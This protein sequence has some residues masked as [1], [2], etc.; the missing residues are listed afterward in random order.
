[1]RL[2]TPGLRGRILLSMTVITAVF[3]GVALLLT[4][5]LTQRWIAASLVDSLTSADRF[6][7]EFFN[8]NATNLLKRTE[9]VA[10]LPT[11]TAVVGA[12]DHAAALEQARYYRDRMGVDEIIIG[13]KQ[14]RLLARTDRPLD[15]G[16]PL[17]E[18][19]FTRALA[20]EAG[21]ELATMGSQAYQA[22]TVRLAAGA[23]TVGTFDAAQRLTDAMAE[24]LR[25]AT[26]WDVSFLVENRVVASSLDPSLRDLLPM[27]LEGRRPGDS[28]AEMPAHGVRPGTTS[29]VVRL[30]GERFIVHSPDLPAATNT[31]TLVCVVQRSLDAALAPYRRLQLVLG[32]AALLATALAG[33][34]GVVVARSVAD[35]VG[36]VAEAARVV[37]AGGWPPPIP[38][39]GGDEM[40]R[41][42]ATFNAMVAS[43]KEN[44]AR[45]AR[46]QGQERLAAVGQLAAG[47]AHDFNN[48]LMGIMS[49]AEVL[50][51]RS[52]LPEVVHRHLA[53]ILQQGE[54]AAKMIRQI[55]DF[56][57]KAPSERRRL[58]LGPAVKETMKLMERTLP[59]D[60]TTRLE[61]EAGEH[62][63]V[64]DLSQFQQVLTNLVVNAR[65]AMGGGGVLHVR[66]GGLALEEVVRT[67]FAELATGDWVLLEVADTGAGIPASV[68]PHI[69][70]PFFTTKGPG[71]GSGLGL[72][73]VYGIVKAHGGFIDVASSEG[74]GT[75]FSLYFPAAPPEAAS[76]ATI[77]EEEAVALRTFRGMTVL[78]VED[79]DGVRRAVR[80]M[81]EA[82]GLNVLTAT[83]G[84]EALA[85]YNSRT[86]PVG[87]VITD[88]VMPEMGG[89]QLVRSLRDGGARAKVILMSGYPLDESWHEIGGDMIV[90][91]VSKPLRL[92]DLA[93]TVRK[94]LQPPAA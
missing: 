71:E 17:R 45:L 81:L 64:A 14:G 21:V 94:A 3:T 51:M 37:Q 77:A 59:A 82:L 42:A 29:S 91:E 31:P 36:H 73:Q 22:A 79:E 60:I 54:R 67:R 66:L 57:R 12:G 72:A 41:L 16:G 65:D 19:R 11:L 2:P 33:L 80:D 93:A 47:I 35:P 7:N 43:L 28:F 38:V 26:G 76:E 56:S 8:V 86:S 85:L 74:K 58:D 68:L 52:D 34:I 27:A 49:F 62:A 40:A 1:M 87:L 48:A 63:V 25:S 84:R 92:R 70:E 24:Y 90:A 5:V 83:N 9:L 88:V 32:L 13:A 18:P 23:E 30:A 4:S 61:L 55:L 69:Y 46:I 39:A 75:T 20:G 44:E 10:A 89:L 53:F 6:V 78:V 15:S 50:R